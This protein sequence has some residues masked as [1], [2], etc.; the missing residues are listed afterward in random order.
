MLAYFSN[1]EVPASAKILAEN[2]KLNDIKTAV[3][4]AFFFA[5]R[6]TLV[7]MSISVSSEI[8]KRMYYS[9]TW[10]PWKKVYNRAGKVLWPGVYYMSAN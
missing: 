10:Y 4:Y 7:N 2:T 3:F 6:A 8:R 5:T 9:S 1:A